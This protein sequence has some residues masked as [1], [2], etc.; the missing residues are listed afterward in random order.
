MLQKRMLTVGIHAEEQLDDVSVVDLVLVHSW[1][2]VG[3]Y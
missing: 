3:R 1:K 2:I